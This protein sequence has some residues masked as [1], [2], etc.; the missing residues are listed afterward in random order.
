MFESLERKIN[1]IRQQPEHIR[2]R[3]MWGALIISMIFIFAI[4][5]MSIR[6]NF[7]HVRNDDRSQATVDNIQQQINDIGDTT[8]RM[9]QQQRDNGVSIQDLLSQPQTQ[10]GTQ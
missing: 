6:I 2:L 5:I 7:V 4:W 1:E 8:Q 3:Y 9:Q 10:Q